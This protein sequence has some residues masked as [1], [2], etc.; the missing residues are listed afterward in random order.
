MRKTV[1]EYKNS[2]RDLLPL[3]V[4]YWNELAS[5]YYILKITFY[6]NSING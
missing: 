1:E 3:A 4:E 2:N 6:L 5:G